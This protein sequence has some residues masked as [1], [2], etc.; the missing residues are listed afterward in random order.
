MEITDF[1]IHGKEPNKEK[2]RWL[3]FYAVQG[4][5][6]QLQGTA[7]DFSETNHW[8]RLPAWAETP[9]DTDTFAV[10]YR[11]ITQMRAKHPFLTLYLVQARGPPP[12]AEYYQLPFKVLER[13]PHVRL[14]LRFILVPHGAFRRYEGGELDVFL[15]DV[16]RE[17]CYDLGGVVR[18]LGTF[19]VAFMLSK[20]PQGLNA[21]KGDVEAS[22]TPEELLQRLMAHYQVFFNPNNEPDFTLVTTDG[23]IMEAFPEKSSAPKVKGEGPAC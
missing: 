14:P 9:D 11:A 19:A 18:E 22:Q 16:G 7:I 17:D 5:V 15:V 23:E 2:R 13:R 6:G 4:T 3:G 1:V 12:T 20:E 21:I 8:P 10:F